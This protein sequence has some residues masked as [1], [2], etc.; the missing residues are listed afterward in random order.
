[1]SQLFSRNQHGKYRAGSI[2]QSRPHGKRARGFNHKID[3]IFEQ[4]KKCHSSDIL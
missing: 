3:V 2:G 4:G 1:M